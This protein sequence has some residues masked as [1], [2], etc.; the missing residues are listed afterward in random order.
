M[1]LRHQRSLSQYRSVLHF[2]IE[3]DET[4]L[5]TALKQ[6]PESSRGKLS[7]LIVLSW[8]MLWW[9][10]FSIYPSFCSCQVQGLCN[11]NTRTHV[12]RG[13]NNSLVGSR[14][15]SSD[16]GSTFDCGNNDTCSFMRQADSWQLVCPRVPLRCQYLIS[17]WMLS[18]CSSEENTYCWLLAHYVLQGI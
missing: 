2:S 11:T 12:G 16:T 6:S 15:K 8:I 18:S 7:Q 10:R 17:C 14:V 4:D 1:K 5:R 9:G 3:R 13:S